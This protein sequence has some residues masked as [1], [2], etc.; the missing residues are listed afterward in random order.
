MRVSGGGERADDA[1]ATEREARS[2]PVGGGPQYGVGQQRHGEQEQREPARRAPGQRREGTEDGPQ[3]PHQRD[4]EQEGARRAQ[5]DDRGAARLHGDDDA[6]AGEEPSDAGEPG[7]GRFGKPRG[8]RGP[9]LHDGA[10]PGV[11]ECA[12]PRH[13]RDEQREPPGSAERFGLDGPAGGIGDGGGGDQEVAPG[14]PAGDRCGAVSGPGGCPRVHALPGGPPQQPHGQRRQQQGGHPHG[15]GRPGERF[16]PYQYGTVRQEPHVRRRVQGAGR[17]AR[18]VRGDRPQQQD[19]DRERAES[20]PG[21][22]G[23]A[24][25]PSAGEG[26][27]VGLAA[28]R[29]QRRTAVRQLAHSAM[30]PRTPVLP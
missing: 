6:G 24:Q 1:G 12:Q 16:V 10:A 21:G 25:Q 7:P 14:D 15:G 19:D 29:G 9:R 23:T 27:G 22:H 13:R 28:A 4:E 26:Q 5:D 8:D 20:E 18:G 30:L 3:V 2:Q 17:V 11:V